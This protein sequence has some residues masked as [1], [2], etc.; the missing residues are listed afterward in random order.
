[1]HPA[2]TKT[3]TELF[4][5]ATQFSMCSPSVYFGSMTSSTT[6]G[7]PDGSYLYGAIGVKDV[8][9]T[10]TLAEQGV[11]PTTAP[12][13]AS[14]PQ[15]ENIRMYLYDPRMVVNFI[16]R[17]KVGNYV[18]IWLIKPKRVCPVSSSNE[19]NLSAHPIAAD[20]IQDVKNV[21]TTSEITNEVITGS[22]TLE[23]PC[24]M[25]QFKDLAAFRRAYKVKRLA[26]EFFL[27]PHTPCKFQLHSK[28]LYR[29]KNEA[30]D[31]TYGVGVNNWDSNKS[32]NRS[33]V[34][35]VFR[36][37]G[38]MGQI[39]NAGSTAAQGTAAFSSAVTSLDIVAQHEFYWGFRNIDSVNRRNMAIETN[40]VTTLGTGWNE[41]SAVDLTKEYMP[42][43]QLEAPGQLT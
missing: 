15:I 40:L 22:S 18:E 17:N 8:A 19:G 35:V 24:G 6:V 32:Y 25:V 21:H 30:L 12:A 42:V 20:F 38:E 31:S 26:A 14:N 36:I 29:I 16:N 34:Q 28:K 27:E 11:S 39:Y 1:M 7:G 5:I 37:R 4:I 2:S 43:E 10:V 23:A 33:T 41:Q 9:G 13:V 3:G